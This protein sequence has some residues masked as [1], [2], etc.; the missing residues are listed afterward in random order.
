MK[1]KLKKAIGMLA[2]VLP[3]SMSRFLQ[4]SAAFFARS[5]QAGIEAKSKH[6]DDIAAHL[7]A[8]FIHTRL[9]EISTG[10]FK[11]K[12]ILQC[13]RRN[14]AQPISLLDIY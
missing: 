5:L 4:K 8:H 12:K 9:S 1:K 3:L 2:G 7:A 10:I 11:R 14:A 6:P 13:G